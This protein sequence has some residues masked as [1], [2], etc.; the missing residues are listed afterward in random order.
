MSTAAT[1]PTAPT[2]IERGTVYT[3]TWRDGTD[4][5]VIE[6]CT[7]KQ[8]RREDGRVPS[9]SVSW[10]MIGSNLVRF[11]QWLQHPSEP[12]MLEFAPWTDVG[13]IA[14]TFA[15]TFGFPGRIGFDPGAHTM[16]RNIASARARE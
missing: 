1:E 16:T 14:D 10:L 8:A 4:A 6:R 11:Q 12:S 3:V 2:E 5:D 13:D 9:E 15:R 7:P